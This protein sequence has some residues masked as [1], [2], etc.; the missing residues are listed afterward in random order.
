MKRGSIVLTKFPFTDLSS[1]KRRPAVI[2][3]KVEEDQ[4]DVIVAFISTKTE[5][6]ISNTDFVISPQNL[7]FTQTGLKSKSV[8]KMNKIAT[9]DKTIFTGEIGEADSLL[10]ED[11]EIR[12]RLALGLK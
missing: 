3:S 6:N 10:L 12:L 5:K 2:I 1:A 9:L 4:Q 8:F 7:S 11:L